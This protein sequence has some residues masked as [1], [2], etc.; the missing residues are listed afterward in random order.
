[1]PFQIHALSGHAF[2]P[3]FDLPD[4]ALAEKG[5]LRVTADSKPGFPCRVS[6]EDADI[7]DELILTHYEH[8][9]E[10]SPYRASH[11]IY[12]RK[13]TRRATLGP[14]TVPASLST[15]LLS[16]RG[17]GA[18]HL[19]READVVEGS[20]LASRLDALFA[21]PGIAYVHIHNAKQGCFAAKA[22]RPA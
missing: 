3:L 2:E 12:I 5:A 19:M 9:S 17:F 20:A 10:N 7:G 21:D 16:V 8:L 1:M 14:D 18:D 4:D 11:A 15:R 22:T 6:L 13:G